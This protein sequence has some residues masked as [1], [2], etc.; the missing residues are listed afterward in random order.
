M[1][2]DTDFH[3]ASHDDLFARS[4][5]DNPSEPEAHEDLWSADAPPL[6]FMSPNFAGAKPPARDGAPVDRLGALAN[7]I[8][9]AG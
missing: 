8:R 1:S 9:R 5:F 4:S 6:P 3:A 7:R 2:G